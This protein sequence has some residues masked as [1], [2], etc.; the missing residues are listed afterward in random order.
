MAQKENHSPAY[1]EEFYRN[2]SSTTPAPPNLTTGH[3]QPAT[4]ETLL[5]ELAGKKS[6]APSFGDLYKRPHDGDTARTSTRNGADE[7]SLSSH[8]SDDIEKDVTFAD[9]PPNLPREMTLLTD[10]DASTAKSSIYYRLQRDKSREMAQKSQEE[11]RQLLETLRREREELLQARQELE[12]LRLSSTNHFPITPSVGQGT[13][14]TETDS[15]GD[16]G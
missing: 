13:T 15:A 7:A 3:K 5:A 9:I 12:R 6:D 14:G 10:G 4:A 2:N 16:P 8:E 11:S 1:N